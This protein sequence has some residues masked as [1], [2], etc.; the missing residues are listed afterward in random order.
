MPQPLLCVSQHAR[1]RGFPTLVLSMPTSVVSKNSS[2]S[3]ATLTFQTVT[4]QSIMP[5]LWLPKACLA[6]ICSARAIHLNTVVLATDWIFTSWV[7]KE[8]RPLQ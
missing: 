7:T 3:V 4:I 2:E 6:A 5:L 1:M 8:C